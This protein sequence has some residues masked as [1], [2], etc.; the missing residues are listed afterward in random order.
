MVGVIA[1]KPRVS[2]RS[3]FRKDPH[4]LTIGEQAVFQAELFHHLPG[5]KQSATRLRHI[6]ES[7]E[8]IDSLFH[9]SIKQH[10][11]EVFSQFL[12]FAR[13][14]NC[15]SAFNAMLIETQRPGATAIR[16]MRENVLG[17]SVGGSRAN[18]KA[19]RTLRSQR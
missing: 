17:N 2:G 15:Y 6:R 7:M 5:G 9:Y 10:G 12:A 13:R 1:P 4:Q 18:E 14:F 3:S 16:F 19:E 8:A 11:L